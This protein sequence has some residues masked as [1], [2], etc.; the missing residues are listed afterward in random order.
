M[1]A[2]T[3]VSS[4]QDL[5]KALADCG[6]DAEEDGGGDESDDQGEG[7]HLSTELK[8]GDGAEEVPLEIGLEEC[9]ALE[10]WVRRKYELLVQT[11][12]R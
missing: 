2:R 5:W 9:K 1:I 10:A 12:E 7:E 3:F 6:G 4:D 8:D 11:E